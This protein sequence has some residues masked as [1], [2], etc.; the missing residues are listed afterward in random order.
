MFAVHASHT[1]FSAYNAFAPLNFIDSIK[2]YLEDVKTQ[3]KK[4]ELIKKHS[5]TSHHISSFMLEFLDESKASNMTNE[6]LDHFLLKIDDSIDTLKAIS[7]DTMPKAVKHFDSLI[8]DLVNIQFKISN[9][10]A[11]RLLANR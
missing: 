6:Q 8:T 7:I 2:V 3:K 4:L 5:D 10:L 1:D 9:I 11:D